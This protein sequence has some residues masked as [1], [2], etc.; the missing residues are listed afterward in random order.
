MTKILIGKVISAGKITGTVTVR[1]ETL[2][3][4]PLYKKMIKKTKKYLV[5]GLNVKEGDKVTIIQTKPVSKLKRFK[6]L[7]VL[8]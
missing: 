4:H 6:I 1:V 5:S 8:Q 3:S 7:E 2:R